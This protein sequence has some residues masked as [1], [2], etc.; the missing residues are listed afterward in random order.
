[1]AGTGLVLNFL[2][3]ASS[4]RRVA[5]IIPKGVGPAVE[6]NRIRRHMREIYRHHQ[7]QLQE[8]LTSVWIV[9]RGARAASQRWL[10]D[11]ML[12]LYRK[13]G[14]IYGC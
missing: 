10:S 5:F 3:S 2:V 12:K 4:P 6:R 1:M 8:G 11:E 13:A 14:L 9:R 7:S